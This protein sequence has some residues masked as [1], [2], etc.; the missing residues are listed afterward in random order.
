M[1][2]LLF[3]PGPPARIIGG[4]S[5][6]FFSPFYNERDVA[7]RQRGRENDACRFTHRSGIRIRA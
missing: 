6:F 7:R 4:V 3:W 2:L 5:V 1:L